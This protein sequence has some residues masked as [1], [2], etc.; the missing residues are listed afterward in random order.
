MNTPIHLSR[1][2]QAIF[3]KEL[4]VDSFDCKNPLGKWNATLFYVDHKKCV[5]IMNSFTK[6]AVILDRVS[7][8]DLANFNTLFIDQL[9]YQLILDEITIDKNELNKLVGTIHFCRTDNDQK[10]IG[11]LNYILRSLPDWKEDYGHIDNWPFRKINTYINGI[12]YEQLGW[13]FPKEKMN[14]LIE[15]IYKKRLLN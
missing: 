3:P 15:D 13:L 5:L 7:K 14:A 9:Y 11:T 4:I 1:K 2:L 12:P 8:A 6:Y 10:T